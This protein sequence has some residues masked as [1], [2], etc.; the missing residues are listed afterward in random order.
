MAR[1]LILH[2]A[3]PMMHLGAAPLIG[4]SY[5]TDH[6]PAGRRAGLGCA[7]F[8]T[9]SMLGGLIANAL[10]WRR[11]EYARHAHLQAGLRYAAAVRLGAAL[12]DFQAAQLDPD[13]QGWTTRGKPEGRRG[14]RQTYENPHVT[15]GVYLADSEAFAALSCQEPS[16]DDIAAA[17]D[18]PARPL[19]I[20][21]KNCAPSE[22]ICAG[23]TEAATALDAINTVAPADWPRAWDIGEGPAAARHVDYDWRQPTGTHAGERRLWVQAP[24]THPLVL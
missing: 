5:P 16:V 4:Q 24:P 15:T 8:P 20:G 13:E 1:Y 19:F 18:Y 3:A 9:P 17:L 7:T 22:R 14:G 10:G 6:P 23:V 2:L 21:R 11:G 12:H